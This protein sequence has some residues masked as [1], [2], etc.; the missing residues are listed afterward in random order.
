[1]LDYLGHQYLTFLAIINIEFSRHLYLSLYSMGGYPSDIN[2]V[3]F[4]S[5]CQMRGKGLGES[6]KIISDPLDKSCVPY[7]LIEYFANMR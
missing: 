3:I 6:Q 2:L 4:H 1:M 5:R 7:N